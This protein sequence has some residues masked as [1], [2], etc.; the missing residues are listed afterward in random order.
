MTREEA[1]KICDQN[2]VHTGLINT[3][4]ALGLAYGLKM[5]FML[6]FQLSKSIEKA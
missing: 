1:F 4:Q 2:K 3:L 5:M 6:F